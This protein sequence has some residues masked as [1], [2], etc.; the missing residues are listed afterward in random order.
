MYSE[1]PN[2]FKFSTEYMIMSMRHFHLCIAFFKLYLT[3]SSMLNRLALRTRSSGD[4]VTQSNK[5]SA[6]AKFSQCLLWIVHFLQE[7][8]K[9][10]EK[11]LHEKV[12]YL[13]SQ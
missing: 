12:L 13:N 1:M 2:K 10:K 9:Y 8:L 3:T 11:T 5:L 4:C 6:I 7:K